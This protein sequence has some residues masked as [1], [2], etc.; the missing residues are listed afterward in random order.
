MSAI[1]LKKNLYSV[2]VLNPGLRVFDIIMESKYGTSYNAYLIT[3]RK[4][5]L[6]DTVHADYFDEYLHNIE[7]VVDVSKIDAL[8]M[9]HTEPDHSGSVAKLLALNPKIR[10]YCTMPAKKNLGAIA[11][12]AFECTVVKQGDSLD[13]GDG[14]LEFIIAPML[15]WPDSMFTWMP[16]Q[17]VL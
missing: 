8:V 10:V 4:N 6:I 1:Q 13:Y 15:H 2:G 5:I 14:R 11:N 12:R 3:G 17:K 7:S 16:E 9:N